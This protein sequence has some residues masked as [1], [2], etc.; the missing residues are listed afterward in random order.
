MCVKVF[1]SLP[2]AAINVAEKARDSHDGSDN[3]AFTTTSR[4][5]CD[6]FL[7]FTEDTQKSKSKLSIAR[8]VSKRVKKISDLQRESLLKVSIVK[9]FE[10]ILI[11]MIV[12]CEQFFDE[13]LYT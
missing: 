7:L 9:L 8:F 1:D 12:L 10:M 11:Q 4:H 3:S 2:F 6:Y 5:Y 13:V